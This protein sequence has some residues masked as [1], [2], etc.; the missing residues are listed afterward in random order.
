MVLLAVL[1]LNLVKNLFHMSTLFFSVTLHCIPVKE[2]KRN[3]AKSMQRVRQKG[4]NEGGG[5]QDR[6]AAQTKAQEKR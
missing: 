1:D 2:Y 4:Q 3:K 6:R 5:E